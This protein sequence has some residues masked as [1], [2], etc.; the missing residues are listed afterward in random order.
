M[1][2]EQQDDCQN[3]QKKN[4]TNDRRLSLHGESLLLTPRWRY[5]HADTQIV[6][7]GLIVVATSAI[8]HAVNADTVKEIALIH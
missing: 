3:Y 8:V 7:L 2:P 1:V 6:T 5:G 4:A